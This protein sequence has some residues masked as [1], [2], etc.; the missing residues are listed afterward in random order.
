MGASLCKMS[1][2]CSRMSTDISTDSSGKTMISMRG[3]VPLLDDILLCFNTALPS[4]EAI[5]S[6]GST[7]LLASLEAIFDVKSASIVCS[8]T[9]DDGEIMFSGMTGGRTGTCAISTGIREH[10]VM[11]CS[12]CWGLQSV[13]STAAESSNCL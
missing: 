13:S 5:A 1:L 9:R 3:P 8:A 7:F 12:K 11:F 2:T 4:S 10:D 6:T